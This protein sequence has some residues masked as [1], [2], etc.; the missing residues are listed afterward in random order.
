MTGVRPKGHREFVQ[1]GLD[2][3]VSGEVQWQHA[4]ADQGGV[5]ELVLADNLDPATRTG[6]R[7]RLVRWDAGT[8][9]ALPVRHDY[10]EEIVVLEGDL[11]VGCGADGRGGQAFTAYSFA[12]RPAGVDHGPFTTRLGCLM[13]ELDLYD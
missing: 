4:R 13:L 12:T 6:S 9:I 5:T 7:T 1:L 3:S 11:V 8:L 2:G 10:R